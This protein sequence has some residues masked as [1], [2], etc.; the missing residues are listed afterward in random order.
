MT[1]IVTVFKE[2]DEKAVQDGLQGH[3]NQLFVI[4]TGHDNSPL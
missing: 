3:N 4:E 2:D 1:N